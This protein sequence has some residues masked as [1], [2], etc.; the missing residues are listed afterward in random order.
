M[1]LLSGRARIERDPL[2]R[3]FLPATLP[4]FWQEA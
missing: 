3:L 2:R 1:T 4:V